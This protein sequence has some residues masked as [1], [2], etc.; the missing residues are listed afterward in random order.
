MSAPKLE[1]WVEGY[2]GYL[3]EVRRCAKRTVVDVRCTLKRATERMA[4]IRPG[5]ELWKLRLEDYL[6]W[7]EQMREAKRSTGGI[8]KQLS[9][10][11]GLLDY[12]WRAGR[13][14]RNVLDG[15]DLVDDGKKVPPKVLTLEEAK[16]MVLACP[17]GTRLER[18]D[19]IVVLILYGCGLRTSEL[20]QLNVDDLDL[21]RREIFVRYGKGDR[22]RKIPVPQGLWTEI[23]AYLGER[24]G[25]RGPLVRTAAKG[26]R[27]GALTLCR[28]VASA[29]ARAGVEGEV[30]PRTLRHTFGSHL[31]DQGVDVSYISSLMGHRSP[32]ETG[33]YLHA[34]PGRSEEA[35]KKLRIP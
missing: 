33:V 12:A 22:Q 34:L 17:R 9:H 11:R 18:R 25:K 13:A 35:V 27:I 8:A 3:S 26:A 32:A 29:A 2:L 19:R 23:L 4:K 16:K 5:V 20:R 15:F 30:T 24:G 7:I 14:D 21:D 1:A 10:V 6:R 31:M 28:I